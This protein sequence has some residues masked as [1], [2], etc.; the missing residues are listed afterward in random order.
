MRPIDARGGRVT[1]LRSQGLGL[2]GALDA[3]DEARDNVED[4]RI[5]DLQLEAG[6]IYESLNVKID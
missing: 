2:D 6:T 4:E 3:R 1:P 5:V